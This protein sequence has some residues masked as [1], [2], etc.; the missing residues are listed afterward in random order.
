MS[1]KEDQLKR[2]V[3]YKAD[4]IPLH[5]WNKQING[6]DRGKTPIDREWNTANYSQD[7]T[8][9]LKWVKSG[10]NIGYRIPENEL[11]VDLDPRNYDEGIDSEKLI[12]DLFGFSDFEELI[13]DVPV[14]KTGGGGYHIYC[15]LPSDVDYR[16][17]RKCVENIPGVDFKKQGG[18]VVAAGSKH[19]SGNYYLWE[20]ETDKA[21]APKALINL[22]KR[23]PFE[24]SEY[25][26]G[27]GA[28][29]GTQLQELI[30][31]KLDISDYDS[32]NVWEPL[33]MAAHHA[34]AGEGIEEFLEWSLGDSKYE[35][36]ENKIRNRWESLD[37]DKEV[38]RKAASLIYELKQKGEDT[39]GAKAV[40]DFST[41]PNFAEADGEDG[42]DGEDTILL[43]KAK[44][45]GEETT[46]AD[47][48]DIDPHE[49]SDKDGLALVMAS[50]LSPT[51]NKDD[52]M[53]CLRLIKVADIIEREEA[54]NK[55]VET[56]R[57]KYNRASLNR[58][59]K[60]VDKSVSKDLH[61]ILSN[62][63]LEDIFNNKRHI[64]V[65]PNNS[66]WVY[67]KTHWEQISIRYLEK[68]TR[69]TL[70]GLAQ[71]MEINTD[72]Y[73][74]IK[75]AT[76]VT[77]SEAS[78][79]RSKLH[80]TDDV[81]KSIITCKNCEIHINDD[82]THT[83]KDHSYMSY[84]TRCLNIEYDPSAKA[85]LFMQTL[86][87]IFANFPDTE[88][89]IRHIGEV[90]GYI[91][92]PNKNLS[93][94][95]LFIGPGGDGKTTLTD[96]LQGV[97]GSAFTPGNTALINAKL[98]NN[99][100]HSMMG[101]VGALALVIGD[102]KKDAVIDDEKIKE[103]ADN[104]IMQANPKGKDRFNFMYS[105]GLI[106]CS[107]HLPKTTDN[108][109]GFQRRVNVIPFN[110][111]FTKGK[112]QDCNR[113]ARILKNPEERAGILNFMLEG[114]QRLRANGRFTPP[115]SCKKASEE[116]LSH[117]N[118]ISRFINDTVEL[119]SNPNDCL[120]DLSTLHSI[121]YSSWCSDNDID[122]HYRLGKLNFKSKLIELGMSVHR[123]SHNIVKVYGGILK[124]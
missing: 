16:L 17:L 38:T 42:E 58:M 56:T 45:V 19:P 54:I 3:T 62:K 8:T 105:A 43:A 91:I 75:K 80:T 103:Y 118:T 76:D 28:F 115:K 68:L 50:A 111:Q 60:E 49:Y 73:M 97:L 72:E 52:L 120:G 113:K 119:T 106:V 114:L 93:S 88:D 30:L 59:L 82:G 15:T 37:G 101:L 48:L 18:Y 83:V 33:M 31:D 14:V 69:R 51:P 78:S 4:L 36:D 12:A 53:K 9:Y 61:I 109:H 121:V 70:E 32:N 92:Q 44:K 13:W 22:I 7:M 41:Q 100:N 122:E 110:A 84:S 40:L 20:N 47:V 86:R 65:E 21:L 89:M 90:F 79:S 71:N 98:S 1:Y 29:T 2:Y 87:E 23:E 107:N 46:L 5:N 124:I 35:G 108:S 63:V 10:Y 25:T 117:T 95:W 74:L 94:W 39:S 67:N 77:I 24:K 34:T 81:P 66:V 26:S 57:G 11:I 104:K 102:F 116:W 112:T 27:Y 6:N 96:I 55:I 64:L 85:P 123:G 99:D